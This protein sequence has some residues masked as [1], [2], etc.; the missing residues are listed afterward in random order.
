MKMR[1]NGR[2]SNEIRPLFSE[3]LFLGGAYVPEEP[4]ED[5]EHDYNYAINKPE[6]NS[7]SLHGNRTAEELHL[8][9]ATLVHTVEHLSDVVGENYNDLTADLQH[10]EGE[11]ET[12]KGDSIVRLD[13]VENTELKVKVTYGDE[14][15]EEVS[16]DHVHG[17]YLT[18]HQDISHLISGEEVAELL[19]D[20]ANTNLSNVTGGYDFVI[21]SNGTSN[22]RLW[23]NGWLECFNT[24]VAPASTGIIEI[25]LPMAY[26]S[27]KYYV[28]LSV[29][30]LGNYFICY[31][32][33]GPQKFSVRCRDMW[34]N[35]AEVSFCW[36]TEGRTR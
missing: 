29:G 34:G 11:I 24:A 2:M 7:V 4:V 28:H 20:K 27:N 1:S 6:I 31:S 22:Y 30:S 16:L 32:I 8:A 17:Q 5:P 21:Q 14:E 35:P 36:K 13:K 25:T 9:P 23:R 33:L 26:A 12:V 10:L 19:D 18:S 3:S 15:S